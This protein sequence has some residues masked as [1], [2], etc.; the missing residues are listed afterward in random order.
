MPHVHIPYDTSHL[1]EYLPRICI[2]CGCDHHN[3]WI[4]CLA[5][6][7][8]VNEYG[9]AWQKWRMREQSGPARSLSVP[10]REQSALFI[11]HVHV[12]GQAVMSTEMPRVSRPPRT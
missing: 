5:Q 3:K 12:T 9:Q 2:D 4:L 7:H 6:F 1:L 10:S 11:L 8:R